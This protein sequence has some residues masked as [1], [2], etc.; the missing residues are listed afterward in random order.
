MYYLVF[1][2]KSEI[3]ICSY[4]SILRDNQDK[5]YIKPLYISPEMD[6]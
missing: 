5:N 2:G 3:R 6:T 4:Y 1:H